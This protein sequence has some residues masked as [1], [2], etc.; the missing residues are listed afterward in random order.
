MIYAPGARNSRAATER[1]DPLVACTIAER[2][3][4][5]STKIIGT[6]TVAR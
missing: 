6:I 5:D 4:V 2:K 3:V 1:Y